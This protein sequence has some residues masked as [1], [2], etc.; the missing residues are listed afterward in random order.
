[1][2]RDLGSIFKELALV[3]TKE[4]EVCNIELENENYNNTVKKALVTYKHELLQNLEMYD[5]YLENAKE[6]I[7]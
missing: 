4:L 2:G 6:P 7:L 5:H 3:K 1:M